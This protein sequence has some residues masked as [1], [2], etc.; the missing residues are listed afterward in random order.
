MVTIGNC[1]SKFYFTV[2]K[3]IIKEIL[4]K[5]ENTSSD[6]LVTPLDNIQDY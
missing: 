2:Q 4:L 6:L 1:C 3:L 5:D